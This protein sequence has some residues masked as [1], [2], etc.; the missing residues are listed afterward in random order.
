MTT[1]T[2]P[3]LFTA[4]GEAALC[5]WENVLLQKEDNAYWQDQLET[6]GF[7]EVRLSMLEIA[8]RIEAAWLQ[9][10]EFKEPF[11]WEFVPQLMYRVIEL[12]G[13]HLATYD[14]Y[15]TAGKWLVEQQEK[16]HESAAD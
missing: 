3:E 11:D 2:G 13:T 5:A 1:L 8:A 15:V 10:G 7:A 12:H 16:Q 6:L 4:I 14:Q 9:C